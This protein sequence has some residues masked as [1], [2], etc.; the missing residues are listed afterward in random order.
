MKFNVKITSKEKDQFNLW[1]I[2]SVWDTTKED[3]KWFFAAS[4]I[5]YFGTALSDLVSM[6]DY[7]NRMISWYDKVVKLNNEWLKTFNDILKKF[8]ELFIIEISDE[9]LPDTVEEMFN[10]T[11]KMK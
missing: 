2:I 10:P 4:I 3:I 5:A 6:K 1:S 11:T 7:L 8:D 9:V